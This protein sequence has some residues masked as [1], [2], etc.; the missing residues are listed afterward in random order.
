MKAADNKR[1][2]FPTRYTAMVMKRQW[3][4]QYNTAIDNQ[5]DGKTAGKCLRRKR[6]AWLGAGLT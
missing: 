2:R 1:L 4:Q 6:S 5:P 3:K